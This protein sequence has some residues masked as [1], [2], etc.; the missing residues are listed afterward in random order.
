MVITPDDLEDR[1]VEKEKGQFKKLEVFIDNYLTENYKGDGS[2]VCV[3]VSRNYGIRE[4]TLKK[5]LEAYVQAGW[6]VALQKSESNYEVSYQGYATFTKKKNTG[7]SERALNSQNTA[8][9]HAEQ[10]VGL[11][12]PKIDEFQKIN[13]DRIDDD[14]TDDEKKID[15][16][17][18][19]GA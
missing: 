7:R 14:K 6:N 16:A 15:Y 9:S 13:D 10:Y 1:I 19:G 2:S 3:T 5:L 17:R 11:E 8:K 4:L 12:E 18:H